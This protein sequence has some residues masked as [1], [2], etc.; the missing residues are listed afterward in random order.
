MATAPQAA[1]ALVCDINVVRAGE[2]LPPLRWDWRL[3]N[4]AQDLANDLAAHGFLS[5]ISSDG[6][7]L[8]ER[9]ASSGYADNAVAPMALENLDWATGTYSTPFATVDGWMGSD[10]HRSHVLDPAMEDVAVGMAE[11]P[12][13]DGGVSGIFYVADFGT[14]GGYLPAGAAASNQP[15]AR[16]TPTRDTTQRRACSAR[17]RL[18]HRTVGRGKR[19]KRRIRLCGQRS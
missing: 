6:R 5:H 9:V 14:R 12:M 18:K 19:V 3:W 16:A 15:G 2:G 4:P 13:K 11:G 1:A 10:A 8:L 17:K 7:G